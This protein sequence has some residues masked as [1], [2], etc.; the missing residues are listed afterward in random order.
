MKKGAWRHGKGKVGQ[1]GA[2][3]DVQGQHL[4]MIS[5]MS[6]AWAGEAADAPADWPPALRALARPHTLQAGQTVFA[7]G[8]TPERVFWIEQ[9]EVRLQRASA[10]GRLIVLQR[11]RQ[12]MDSAAL[13]GL[14]ELKASERVICF[15]AIGTVTKSKENRQRPTPD[16]FVSAL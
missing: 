12:S 16:R 9:G 4:P 15:V 13:R 14:F 5:I 11:V 8:E 3:D 6:A 1:R 10:E 2:H 7:R